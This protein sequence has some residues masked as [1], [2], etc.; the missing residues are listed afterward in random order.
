MMSG[1]YFLTKEQKDEK[2]LEKKKDARDI[3]RQERVEK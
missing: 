1:E 2:L 3:R